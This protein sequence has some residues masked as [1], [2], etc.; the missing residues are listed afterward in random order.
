MIEYNKVWFNLVITL[1]EI[2][3]QVK[4]YSVLEEEHSLRV[5]FADDKVRTWDFTSLNVYGDEFLR[6]IITSLPARNPI[7]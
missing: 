4:E 6:R 1:L 7:D 3:D 5:V 2:S